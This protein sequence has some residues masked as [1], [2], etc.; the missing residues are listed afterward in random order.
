M[1]CE[2]FQPKDLIAKSEEYLA[3]QNLKLA[4][5]EGFRFSFCENIDYWGAKSI[6]TEVCVKDGNWVITKIERNKE[7][8]AEEQTGFKVFAAKAA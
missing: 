7:P 4:E 1:P 2:H 8:V 5:V 3:A 6:L